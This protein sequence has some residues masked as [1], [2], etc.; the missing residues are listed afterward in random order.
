MNDRLRGYLELLRPHN[1]LVSFLTTIIGYGAVIKYVHH[2][3]SWLT[4][5][6]ASLIVVLIAAGGYVINDYYDVETDAISKPWRPIVRGAVRRRDA[7]VLA[8]SL[9]LGG[10]VIS[11]AYS[12]YI[13]IFSLISALLV[14]EYSRWI[15]RTGFIGN[16]SVAVESAATIL[17]GGFF[18]AVVLNK[19]VPALVLIPVFYA[20]L[21]VL[22]RE[23]VKGIEDVKGDAHANIYTLAVTLGPRKAAIIASI[24]LLLVVII[25]PLPW[26]TRIYNILYLVFAIGVDATIL[27]SVA[28]LLKHS[29]EE[30]IIEA[31]KKA[32]SALKVGFLLGGLAFLLGLL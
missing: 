20:F 1:L 2:Y 32:R 15:K 17:F 8:Y 9:F 10:L 7:R 4:C 5:V 26:F 27:Y 23:I 6:A 13:L 28:A 14:H 12:I 18:A 21:L 31:S 30:S 24:L 25:S 22:G 19:Q 29:D 3:P 11:A 16:I